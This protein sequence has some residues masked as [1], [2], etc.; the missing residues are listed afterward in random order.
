VNLA[1][2]EETARIIRERAPR[3]LTRTKFEQA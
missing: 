3:R 2:A 1:G